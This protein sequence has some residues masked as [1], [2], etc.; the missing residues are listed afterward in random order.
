MKKN[1]LFILMIA[2]SAI[3]ASAQSYSTPHKFRYRQ[4]MTE[5]ELYDIEFLQNMGKEDWQ[6]FSQDPRFNAD[7]VIALKTE[8][9]KNHRKEH[10][11][12]KSSQTAGQ[13]NCYWIEPTSDWE[14]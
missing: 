4:N 6:Q 12:P 5:K 14:H 11:T 2:I 10:G 7:K 13:T 3:Q 8:W 9:K 1:Y